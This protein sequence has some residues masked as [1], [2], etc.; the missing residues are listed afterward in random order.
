AAVR[1]CS[2]KSEHGRFAELGRASID[3]AENRAAP[4][5][6]LGEWPACDEPIDE[7][8]AVEGRFG[9]GALERAQ[10]GD[11][12]LGKSSHPLELGEHR[13]ENG[14]VR[15]LGERSAVVDE[16]DRGR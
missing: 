3:E 12:V 6:H 10:L 4:L 16:V 9:L 13:V 14:E 11:E 15:P 1:Y 5:E 8:S 7:R 2:G